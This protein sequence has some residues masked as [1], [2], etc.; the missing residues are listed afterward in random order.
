MSILTRSL[1]SISSNS[2]LSH[3]FT[4][5]VSYSTWLFCQSLLH[6]S[7]F[8]VFLLLF[9]VRLLGRTNMFYTSSFT[10][11]DYPSVNDSDHVTLL[12]G[13][14]PWLPIPSLSLQWHSAAWPLFP[15]PAHIFHSRNSKPPMV[16]RAHYFLPNLLGL[17]SIVPL[18]IKALPW[19]TALILQIFFSLSVSS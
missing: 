7:P 5:N 14:F 16:P 10:C 18:S 11:P 13:T 2:L 3:S 8:S 12:S 1:V 15:S 17:S 6:F 4:F 9:T 19:L